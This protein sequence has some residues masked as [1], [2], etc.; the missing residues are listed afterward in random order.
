MPA[1]QHWHATSS[2]TRAYVAASATGPR[3]HGKAL[4]PYRRHHPPLGFFFCVICIKL[5]SL[6]AL[7]ALHSLAIH[8][9]FASSA[10]PVLTPAKR[11]RSVSPPNSEDR[12][13]KPPKMQRK[14]SATRGK[15]W[16]NLLADDHKGCPLPAMA[17]LIH[18]AVDARATKVA[19]SK[20]HSKPAP[21]IARLP[22]Y[23]QQRL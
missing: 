14:N 18:N 5:A 13:C 1:H 20:V 15:T 4:A 2:G 9:C 21:A 10:R 12:N 6:S 23:V 11:L 19:I 7:F 3:R 16:L 8:P 17:E 22:V